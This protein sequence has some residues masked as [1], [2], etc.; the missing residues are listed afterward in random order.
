[1][2]SK[3]KLIASVFIFGTIGIFANYIPLPSSVIAM[4]RGLVGALFL[5]LA[6]FLRHSRPNL[7]SI[8]KNLPVLLLSGAVLGGNWIL[9]FE[10]YKHT[11]VATATL[12]Y[13]LAPVFVIFLSPLLF[14]EKLTA[15]KLCCALVAL[16]GMIPVSGILNADGAADI[17]GIL[18]GVG[19]ALLYTGVVVLNKKLGGVSDT[20][21][22]L[23]QLAAAGIVTAPY[24]LLTQD[25]T[26]LSITATQ[27][28]LLLVVCVIHTGLAYMLYLS[29]VNELPAQTV[30][31]FSYIDPITAILLSALLLHEPLGVQGIV[32][33]VLILGATFFS[34]IE[35]KKRK[36]TN[37]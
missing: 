3:T 32:G 26:A 16:C 25:I 13:Y 5:L 11:G 10:A 35:L 12:C 29:S 37:S 8:R 6:S 2:S 4:S 15:K 23:V 30:A 17:G 14:G 7:A 27:L 34:E 20:D 24:A 31:I 28:L 22:S 19:A 1:M 36:T 18:F 33:A 21:R 9:L